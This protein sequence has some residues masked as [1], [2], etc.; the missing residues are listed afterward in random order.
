MGSLLGLFAAVDDGDAVGIPD[1]RETVRHDERGPP[2][3]E[4]L[5]PL[6]DKPLARGVDAR[7]R[8]VQYQDLR[9]EGDRPGKR[10]EL[11]LPCGKVH[12]AL[13]HLFVVPI[14]E[15]PD[16]TVRADHLGR[17]FHPFHR[18]RVAERDVV[19]DGPGEEIRVLEHDAD[20]ATQL[21]QRHLAHIGPVDGD[22]AALH[23][24][25]PGQ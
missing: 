10:D 18:F 23:V 6:L 14:R 20:P 19:G 25:K 4:P 8:L 2:L 11:A 5:E 3:H 9:V 21:L 17:L 22:R 16:E 7:R 24:V 12:A 15:F 13:A 1:R